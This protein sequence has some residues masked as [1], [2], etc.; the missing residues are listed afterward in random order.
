MPHRENRPRPGLSQDQAKGKLCA[1]KI[2]CRTSSSSKSPSSKFEMF[3]RAASVFVLALPLLTA[4]SAIP[5][6]DGSQCTTG[7]SSAAPQPRPLTTSESG[8][9]LLGL[10]GIVVGTVEGL[11]G[12]N[13]SPLT[14]IGASGT[15]CSEQ[16]VCCTGNTFNGLITLG[17]S[18]ININL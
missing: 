17:C 2:R 10:L 8:S 16:P 3:A 5:R 6:N 14:I 4:A 9:L 11:I 13:C 7:S 18:P 15:S 1:D 12:L